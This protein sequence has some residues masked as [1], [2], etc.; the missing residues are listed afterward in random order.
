[1]PVYKWSQTSNS[2]AT[3]DSTVNYSEG[4]APSS[5]NDSARAAMAAIAMWR[6]DISGAIATTGTSSAYLLTSASSFNSLT[7]LNGQ[8]ISF[9]PHVT[10]AGA[11]TLNTDSLTAKPLRSAPNVEIPSGTLIQGTPYE[12]VYNNADGA[13]YLKG[14]YGSP[15]LI[16]L[17]GLLPYAG[18][19]A[20][21]STFVLPFGQAI[22]R[23]TYATLFS[24]IGSTYGAGDG[25]TTF[26]LPDLRGRVVAS[27]DNMGGGSDPNRLTAGALAGV[28]NSIGGAGGE[29]AHTQTVAEMPAHSHSV[30]VS[31]PGHS[32]AISPTAAQQGTGVSGGGGVGIALVGAGSTQGAFT[33]IGVSI[34]NNGSGGAFNVMQPTILLN[35]IMR[36]I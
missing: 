23:I 21:N 11:C 9:V 18:A 5:L 8:M 1:M 7:S 6:D 14:F 17:G 10:N 25:S 27:P 20:P 29:S 28:R 22:S 16:P 35:Q 32:H 13:F 31:D 30:N 26:N 2:N 3:A 4:Q 33:G 34:N 12:A 15:Y 36:V 24:L 19:T